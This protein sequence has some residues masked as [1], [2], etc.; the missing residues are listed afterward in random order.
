MTHALTTE[1]KHR[2]HLFSHV[3]AIFFTCTL[4]ILGGAWERYLAPLKPGGS[5]LS[6]KIL[7]LLPLL[8]GML[9][10]RRRAFQWM[11]LLIWF[12][13]IEGITRGW[14]EQGMARALAFSE[15]MLSLAIFGASTLW[16]RSQKSDLS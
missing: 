5:L 9:K 4:I 8:W 6:L 11:V 1:S 13:M 10:A 16:I 3:S 2:L 12:Y 14:T 15:I 7:P